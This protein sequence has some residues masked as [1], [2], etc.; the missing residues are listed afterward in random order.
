MN[1]QEQFHISLESIKSNNR[2]ALGFRTCWTHDQQCM[3]LGWYL[4]PS[5]IIPTFVLNLSWVG[6]RKKYQY[7]RLSPLLIFREVRAIHAGWNKWLSKIHC[8]LSESM[9]SR[10]PLEQQRTILSSR[11]TS[12]SPNP[13]LKKNDLVLNP[14]LW[15]LRIN[16]NSTSL[17]F[18]TFPLK[19][20]EMRNVVL[21]ISLWSTHLNLDSSMA[22]LNKMWNLTGWKIGKKR[23]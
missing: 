12:S 1:R 17:T 23:H 22:H 9:T 11:V 21:S 8:T 16:I 20:Y 14:T 13:H 15:E 2:L 4:T 6:V 7:H 3:G 10:G 18:H 5:S 19:H